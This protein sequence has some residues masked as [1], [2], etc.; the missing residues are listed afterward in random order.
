MLVSVH[1]AFVGVLQ[2]SA[3]CDKCVSLTLSCGGTLSHRQL[4]QLIH[5]LWMTMDDNVDVMWMSFSF[6]GIHSACVGTTYLFLISRL[7]HSHHIASGL[8]KVSAHD[9]IIATFRTFGWNPRLTQCLED[10]VV[11]FTN[12]LV[13][14]WTTTLGEAMLTIYLRQSDALMHWCADVQTHFMETRY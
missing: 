13:K 12:T 11:L 7:V 5:T 10:H 2:W 9:K 8:L 6:K 1:W 4:N 3:D 14:S